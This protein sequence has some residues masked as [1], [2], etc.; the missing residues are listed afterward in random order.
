MRFLKEKLTYSGYH[1]RV[2]A[3]RGRPSVCALC[4]KKDASRYEWANLRG[5]FGDIHDYIRLCVRCHRK[6]DGNVPTNNYD[7]NNL[8][9]YKRI[10]I[11][12]RQCPMCLKDHIP[13]IYRHS[14]CSPKC[15]NKW[16]SI[17]R[18]RKLRGEKLMIYKKIPMQGV[19]ISK[20]EV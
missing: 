6:L 9:R 19:R 1:Y 16:I 11:L 20:T 14:F 13:K 5:N 2:T 10:E 18:Q 4:D 7:N 12:P 17:N 3:L 15:A 8:S